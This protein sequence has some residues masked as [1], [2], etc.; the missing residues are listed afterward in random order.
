MVFLNE[1]GVI[2]AAIVSLSGVTGSIFL[3]LLL[4]AI[5]LMVLCLAFGLSV[6]WSSLLLLPLFLTLMAYDATFYSA[7]GALLLYLAFILAKNFFFT[8]R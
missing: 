1:T 7:G 2:G 8:N 5:L 3:T 6:E 4:L